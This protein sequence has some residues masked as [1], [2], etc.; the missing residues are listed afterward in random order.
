MGNIDL[1]LTKP[2]DPTRFERDRNNYV[3]SIVGAFWK[4]EKKRVRAAKA[5]SQEK[6]TGPGAKNKTLV[7]LGVE[8]DQQIEHLQHELHKKLNMLAERSEELRLEGKTASGNGNG[9]RVQMILS[10]RNQLAEA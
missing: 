6:S 9:D 7:T 10:E 1:V 5:A 8:R 4:E 2:H 3:V